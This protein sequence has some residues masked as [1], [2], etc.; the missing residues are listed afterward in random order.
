MNT[1]AI[2]F[3]WLLTFDSLVNHFVA[4]SCGNLPFPYQMLRKSI[5]CI[6]IANNVRYRD[7]LTLATRYHNIS[8]LPTKNWRREAA[9][10][11]ASMGRSGNAAHNAQI[12]AKNERQ[13]QI[14]K[15]VE[16][17]MQLRKSL[18]DVG[19]VSLLLYQTTKYS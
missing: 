1:T 14:I 18:L 15:L 19:S 10:I 12:A 9:T 2:N 4:H 16:K 3:V 17:K 6:N 8:T 7:T 5:N 11:T 13:Q